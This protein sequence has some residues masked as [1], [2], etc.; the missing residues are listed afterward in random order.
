MFAWVVNS[1]LLNGRAVGCSFTAPK[2]M[3]WLLNK[4][5]YYIVYI[6]FEFIGAMKLAGDHFYKPVSMMYHKKNFK[7]RMDRIEKDQCKLHF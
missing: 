6:G 3:L 4:M 5:V 1:T 2:S 7:N